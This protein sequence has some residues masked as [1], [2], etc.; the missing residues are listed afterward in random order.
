MSNTVNIR[1]TVSCAF[2]VVMALACPASAAGDDVKAAVN[3]VENTATQ[4]HPF[5]WPISNDVPRWGDVMKVRGVAAD[6]APTADKS[7]GPATA[8]ATP[9]KTAPKKAEASKVENTATVP[10]P[11]PWPIA[12]DVPRWGD[13]MK[14][15][16]ANAAGAAAPAAA[17]PQSTGAGCID[18][19]KR[20][21]SSGAIR[22]AT[23]SADLDPAS[24]ASLQTLANTIKSCGAVKV[25]IEAFTDSAGSYVKNLRLSE[26]RADA[27]VEYLVK[28]G[29]PRS[30]LQGRGL[31]EERPVAPNDT[32]ENRQK[33]R[34]IEFS[35][36]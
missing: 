1:P 26:R 31:G 32:E 29:V 25:G 17:T 15:R 22:F 6:P 23:A 2:L 24:T 4:P 12:Q 36:K 18:E 9:D 21:A 11:F 19:L 13:V 5:P 27:V 34:R 7:D 14:V 33:N 8:E 3:K 28:T 16:M 35:V 30:S 20:I 10:H